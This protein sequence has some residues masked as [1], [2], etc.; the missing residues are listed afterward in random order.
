[1]LI[2]RISWDEYFIEIVNVV[3]KRS[4]CKRRQV[5]ALIVQDNMIVS[6]GYNGAPK[7]LE[8]C[9]DIER[10]RREELN[11]PSGQRHEICIGL[12]AE[13]NSIIQ[14]S[15]SGTKLNGATMYVTH[16]PCIICSKMIINSGIKKVVYSE[17]YSDSLASEILKKAGIEVC[18]FKD[19]L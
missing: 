1:M 12:H 6:M 15:N 2:A 17:E 9:I 14:A 11:V 18:L 4:T 8:H 10:C 7:T 5:G 3:K 19:I 16:H 13:Q